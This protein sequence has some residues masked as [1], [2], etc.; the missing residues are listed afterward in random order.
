[1]TPVEPSFKELEGAVIKMG[2]VDDATVVDFDHTVCVSIFRKGGCK[3]AHVPVCQHMRKPFQD[4][5]I[6]FMENP[7]VN[8]VCH[9]ARVREP[10]SGKHF[11]PAKVFVTPEMLGE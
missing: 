3:R 4:R 9:K 5:T 7:V 8:K 11:K 6:W 2:G 1:M 10:G